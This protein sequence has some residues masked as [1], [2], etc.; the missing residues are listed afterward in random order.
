MPPVQTAGTIAEAAD[1]LARG[2]VASAE[3]VATA[4]LARG[5]DPDALHLL[6]LARIQQN[7]L[8]DAV[9]LL[10]RSL[11]VRPAHAPVLLNLG[12]VLVLLKRDGEA[13][14]PL[15]EAVLIQPDLAEAWYELGE[16][17]SR[18]GQHGKAEVSMRRVLALDP[19]HRLAAL[20]LGVVLKDSG[21]P[22][23]AEI[24]LAE[25]LAKAGDALLK[26]A[27]HYQLAYAQFDQGK[28][29]EALANFT[30]VR[31]RDPGRAGV[32]FSRAELLVEL[33]RPDEAVALLED[34]LRREPL[35]GEAHKVYNDLIYRLGRDGEFLKSYDRAPPALPL[36]LGKAAFLIQT[37]RV[38]EALE[39]YSTLLRQDAGQRDAALG[40]AM[41]LNKMGRHGEA[42]THLEQ[43]RAR[44]PDNAPLLNRLAAT[45]L[46]ARDAGKAV[47]LAE[48]AL[49]LA[50]MDHYGLALLGSAWRMMGDE[51]DENLNGYDDLIRI[52][53]LEA[54]EGFSDMTEFNAAL[55]DALTALHT[56]R[57]EPAEQSLRGGSQTSGPLF[58]ARHD[59]VE[60]IRLRIEGAVNRYI[61]EMK[62]D[63]RHPF[64]GRRSAGFRFSGSWSSRLRDCGYHVNHI[65]PQ[66][67]ISSCYYVGV[68]EAVKDHTARQGWIKFGEPDF[69]VG[70]APRR[71]IQP[72]PGR[73]VLFPSYMWH[74]T[75]PFHENAART[76]V[77][78]D[79]VP[80]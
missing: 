71:A 49:R 13:A 62:P 79:A 54:P 52:F 37:G 55:N 5:D 59:L 25:G 11:A 72:V 45:A 31:R 65:H 36:K 73:L 39:I 80:V 63:V 61:A 51:R 46:Q 57:R 16:L 6:A 9:L 20:S 76:T 1:F 78:F 28:K 43:I 58:G 68:P 34:V 29:T 10:G 47:L 70:L 30:E 3:R 69:D 7:R 4:L 22:A 67:W 15:G 75:I 74:G 2:D 44:S 40:A 38:E 42:M 19:D 17:Q 18:L 33:S 27:F 66:G 21:R 24:L 56:N 26:T 48:Q 35:N 32:D 12:K 8:E 53:D 64:R 77:A 14:A 60:R 41:A 50:P 23:E